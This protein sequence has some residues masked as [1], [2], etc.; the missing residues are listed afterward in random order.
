MLQATSAFI[1]QL[2]ENVMTSHL[3]G[4]DSHV[5]A[6]GFGG[7]ACPTVDVLAQWR[8]QIYVTTDRCVIEFGCEYV[9]A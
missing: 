8:A 9:C 6:L 2:P 1:R 5:R 4:P 7:E 3:L